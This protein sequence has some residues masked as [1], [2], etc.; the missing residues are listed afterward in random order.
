MSES[1]KKQAMKFMHL[2][3]KSHCMMAGE[4]S[5]EIRDTLMKYQGKVPVALA[6]GVL[7]IVKQELIDEHKEQNK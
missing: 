6:V 3:I 7:D 4:M 1:I 2:A 5:V